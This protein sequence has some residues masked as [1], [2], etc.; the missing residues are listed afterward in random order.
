VLPQEPMQSPWPPWP[1]MMLRHHVVINVDVALALT[2]GS[3]SAA[4]SDVLRLRSQG[5]AAMVK[6]RSSR[7]VWTVVYVF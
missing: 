2:A 4:I 7:T 3:V 5:L 6:L 1:P